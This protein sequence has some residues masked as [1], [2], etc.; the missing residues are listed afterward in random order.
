MLDIYVI[1]DDLHF[2]LLEYHQGIWEHIYPSNQ[3][4]CG[5]LYVRKQKEN[6]AAEKTS[7][8]FK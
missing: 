7:L 2:Y 8:K 3:P 5:S 4:H 6:I 1:C